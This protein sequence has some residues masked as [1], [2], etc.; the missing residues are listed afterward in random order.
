MAT[1]NLE[2]SGQA[3]AII[4]KAQRDCPAPVAKMAG[5]MLGPM[6]GEYFKAETHGFLD[7]DGTGEIFIRIRAAELLLNSDLD[8]GLL[9]AAS[10]GIVKKQ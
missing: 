10:A 8:A 7:E 4:A 6:T 9:A 3:E 1:W 2:Y 5:V